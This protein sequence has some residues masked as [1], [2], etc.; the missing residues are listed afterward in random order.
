MTQLL[1]KRL[2]AFLI[3]Y[4]VIAGYAVV[5][6]GLAVLGFELF[7]ASPAI[8]NPIVGQMVG[9]IT[10]T[11]PVFLYFF[12][13]EKGKRKGTIGKRKLKIQVETEAV[14]LTRNMLLR[15]ILKLLPWEIAHTGVHWVVYYSNNNPEVPYWIWAFLIIPQIAVVLYF[16]SII[17]Y[18]GE[19]SFYDKIAKTKI[20]LTP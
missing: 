17:F 2:F 14:N 10:L 8:S 7:G 5:L 15:N 11:L 19:S 20:V 6:F 9:F 12:I 3:D 16:F 18:K 4:L 1:Q 13:T